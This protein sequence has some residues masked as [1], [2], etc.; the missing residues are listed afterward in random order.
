MTYVSRNLHFATPPWWPCPRRRY[1]W[2]STSRMRALHECT[3]MSTMS[4]INMHDIVSAECLDS[5]ASVV[6]L[7]LRPEKL[8]IGDELPLA[9]TLNSCFDVPRIASSDSSCASLSPRMLAI[10]SITSPALSSSVVSIITYRNGLLTS[11]I[12]VCPPLTIAASSGVGMLAFKRMA[13]AWAA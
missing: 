5:F 1:C 13:S 6:Y 11:T 4:F 7:V 3:R 2:L 12:I 10:L 9:R 8:M